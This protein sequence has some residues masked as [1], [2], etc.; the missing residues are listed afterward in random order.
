MKLWKQ[1][2]LFSM[3]KGLAHQKTTQW[4]PKIAWNPIE[5][6]YHVKSK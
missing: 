2:K 3:V 1:S 6:I 5:L 4:T